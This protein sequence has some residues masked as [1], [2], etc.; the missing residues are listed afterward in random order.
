ME[1]KM[2]LLLIACGGLSFASAVVALAD[3]RTPYVGDRLIDR[4]HPDDTRAG[5]Q[6]LN[7][8]HRRRPRSEQRRQYPEVT[9]VRGGWLSCPSSAE[10]AL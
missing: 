3:D 5:S 6:R 1:L 7:G 4:H 10:Q 2:V 8:P 9:A